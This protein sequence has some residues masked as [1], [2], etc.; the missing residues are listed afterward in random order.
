MNMIALC[1]HNTPVQQNE[2]LCVRLFEMA[3]AK[4]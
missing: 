2:Y 3:P 4:L 1:R